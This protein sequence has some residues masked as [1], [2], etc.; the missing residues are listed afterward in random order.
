MN[1]SFVKSRCLILTVKIAQYDSYQN[2]FNY[3]LIIQF[4]KKERTESHRI[5]LDWLVIKF[6]YNRKLIKTLLPPTSPRSFV[7]G[8]WIGNK[9]LPLGNSRAN[10]VVIFPM[11]LPFHAPSVGMFPISRQS[12]VEPCESCHNK[13]PHKFSLFGQDVRK[14]IVCSPPEK[15][16]LVAKEQLVRSSPPRS[17]DCI[18]FLRVTR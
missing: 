11:K 5:S 14:R 18:V 1:F 3:Y 10:K 6:Y 17:T 13:F 16:T 12:R 9:S 8:A 15:G 2:Y 4:R 7:P